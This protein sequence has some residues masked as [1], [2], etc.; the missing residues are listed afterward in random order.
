V[1]KEGGNEWKKHG[2]VMLSKGQERRYIEIS[3]TPHESLNVPSFDR[4]EQQIAEASQLEQLRR[5]NGGHSKLWPTF[6]AQSMHQSF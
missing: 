2:E 5:K 6:V 3:N 1:T 4:S